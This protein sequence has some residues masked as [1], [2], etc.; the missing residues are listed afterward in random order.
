MIDI[1]HQWVRKL[2]DK[3]VADTT[4]DCEFEARRIHEEFTVYET[5]LLAL[6]AESKALRI[7][8]DL[9][10]CRSGGSCFRFP[11]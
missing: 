3:P 2:T 1:F 8:S 11:G 9:L 6:V 4:P 7:H 10:F 5:G